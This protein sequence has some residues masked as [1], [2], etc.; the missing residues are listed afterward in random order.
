MFEIGARADVHVQP[1][2]RQLVLGCSP[3]TVVDLLVPNAVLRLCAAS[4]DFLTM[5]MSEAWIDSQS[6]SARRSG[7]SPIS[8]KCLAVLID[9][10]RRAAIDMDVSL[11]HKLQRLVIKDVGRVNNFRWM[12]RLPRFET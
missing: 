7:F 10:I 8:I 5:S 4:V 11:N 3:N 2:N 6:Y 9:H 1:G 12:L